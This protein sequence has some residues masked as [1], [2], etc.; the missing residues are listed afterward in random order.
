[1]HVVDAACVGQQADIYELESE[2]EMGFNFIRKHIKVG[3]HRWYYHADRLGM[4]VWQ[5][6]PETIH[7]TCVSAFVFFFFLF[8]FSFPSFSLLHFF[9]LFGV[10]A[11]APAPPA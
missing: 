1:M 5:D 8:L 7:G 11:S 9:P 4:M 10:A 3:P 6:M 2:K